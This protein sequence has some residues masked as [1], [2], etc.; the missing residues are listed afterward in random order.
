MATRKATKKN[1]AR[2]GGEILV[3][4]TARE[5][6]AWLRANHAGSAGVFLRI[7]RK[8][9]SEKGL[10]YESALEAALVG[11]IDSQKRALD[12]SSWLQRFTPRAAR[13]PWSKINRARSRR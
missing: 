8:K 1:P 5:W 11:W 2:N 3:L 10:T 4:S 9:Q 6:H 12:E 13:S 7:A